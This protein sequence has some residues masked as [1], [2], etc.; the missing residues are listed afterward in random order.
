MSEKAGSNTANFSSRTA[1]LEKWLDELVNKK[2]PVQLPG[3]AKRW[4]ADNVWWIVIIGGVLSLWSA[5]TFWQLGHYV[6]G[7]S[8]YVN[9][10]S[11]VY[12]STTY[13]TELGPMWYLALVGLIIEGILLLMAFPKLKEH[14]KSGWDLLFYVSLVNI[15]IGVVYLL[16]PGYGFGSLIGTLLG[17]AIGWFFLFQI[18]SRFVR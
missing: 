10:L 8:R 18:R 14:K 17:A 11:R 5:W 4:I 2:Q 12:G 1:G 7:L 15:V 16:V 9:E 13:A 3:E 6:D